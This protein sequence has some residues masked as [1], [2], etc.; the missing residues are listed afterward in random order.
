M[1]CSAARYLAAAG[2]DIGEMTQ[3]TI[4]DSS[5]PDI[6]VIG[7]L[8]ASSL[9]L[10]VIYISHSYS[11]GLDMRVIIAS[12]RTV[13]QLAVLGLILYPIFNNNQ[14]YVVLP[15]LLLMTSFAAREASVKPA[16]LYAKLRVHIFTAIVA[17]LG[18]S[19]LITSALVMRPWPWWDAQ[20]MIPVCGMLLGNSIN[21][22]SLGIDRYLTA[23]VENRDHLDALTHLGAT[24]KEAAL[25]G[26]R[27]ALSTGLTPTLNQ[28]SVI[29]LVSIPGMMTGQV[30][31]GSPPLL[32]AKYQAVIMFLICFMSSCVLGASL[33]LAHRELFDAH[34]R[35]NVHLLTKRLGGKPQDMLLTLIS[36]LTGGLRRWR[37]R[38]QV[39]GTMLTADDSAMS[40]LKADEGAP[41][42]VFTAIPPPASPDLEASPLL[43]L[44]HAA[45]TTLDGIMLVEE[46][47]LELTRGRPL[48]ITGPSGCGKS[49]LLK[50]LAHL[51]PISRGSLTLEGA[52][53]ATMGAAAWRRRVC[54]VRQQGGAGLPGTPR[55]LFT[56]AG[57]LH[58]G[59][60]VDPAS[61]LWPASVGTADASLHEALRILDLDV[62]LLDRAWSTLSG[63]QSQRV[64]LAIM[65]CR[66]PQVVLLDEVTSACDVDTT[67]LVEQ[68]IA[69]SGCASIWITHSMEQAERIAVGGARVEFVSSPMKAGST[70]VV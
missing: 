15:Y 17:S 33:L 69:Q 8:F 34:H 1:R 11:L 55:E 41:S 25:P 46:A 2:H 10:F 5:P 49:S 22:L 29:G 35:L 47:S 18:I 39:T 50:A 70:E 43:H 65:V 6:G 3:P 37:A 63:G 59:P 9:M 26:V 58:A 60:Q 61:G 14:P 54:Y 45:I 24:A 51:L 4:S 67:L 13:V 40:Q 52:T 57:T 38:L 12:I 66:R 44:R 20:T 32:A 30:L 64:Y 56:L 53:P 21:S 16:Y 48:V 27:A 36:H 42:G 31:G 62:G 23:L 28:M 7:L 68:L 19:F